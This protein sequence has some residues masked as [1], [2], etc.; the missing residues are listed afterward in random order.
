[1]PPD[2]TRVPTWLRKILLRG[3]ATRPGDRY[4]SMAEMLSA[5]AHDPAT[6]RKR[7]GLVALGVG[8]LASAIV[9]TAH[10]SAGQRA[11]CAGG[12]T[13]AAAVW[14]TEQRTAVERAFLAS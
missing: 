5:L 14:G 9:G 12:Q 3:L 8:L 13:R 10:L 2:G 6:R 1:E 11:M 4:P 7:L